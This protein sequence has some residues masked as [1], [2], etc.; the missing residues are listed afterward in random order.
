MNIKKISFDLPKKWQEASRLG[1]DTSVS[2]RVW[3]ISPLAHINPKIFQ[4]K[5]ISETANEIVVRKGVAPASG[6]PLNEFYEGMKGMISSGY[7]PPEWNMKKLDKL[8]KGMTE[9]K[10][11][12]QPGESDLS[13]E[14]TIARCENEKVAKQMLEN[15]GL[16]PTKGFDVPI[17]GMSDIPGMPKNA[18]LVE[19]LQSDLLKGQVPAEDL[20]KL[21]SEIQKVQEQMPAVKKDLAKSGIQYKPGKYLGYEAIVVHS[22]KSK[23]YQALRVKNFI[24]TGMLLMIAKNLSSGS[25]PCDSLTKLAPKPQITKSMTGAGMLTIK[26]FSPAKSTFA[27]EGYLHKQEIDKIFSSAI[28][29]IKKL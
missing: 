28:F 15:Y 29:A 10:H 3:H 19:Y 20:E 24:I 11:A 8:W 21:K 14:I 26:E 25:T 2:I 9:T 17:P 13:A 23:C 27:K 18:T 16:M 12:E 5:V 7:M 22:K 4:D 6:A 1:S